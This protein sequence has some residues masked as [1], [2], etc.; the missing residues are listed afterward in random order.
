[1][2]RRRRFAL[3]LAAAA[4]VAVV[5]V[6]TAAALRFTDDSFSPP[7]G[8][9]GSSYSHKLNGDG[10]C[11]PALPYQFRVLNGAL[12]PGLSLAS[13]GQISGTP[14]QSGTYTFW[15]ELSDENPPSAAWCVPKT[16]EREFTIN[17]DPGLRILT[18]SLPQGASVGAPYSV[19]LQ[20]MLVT[21]LSPL[22]GSQPEGLTWSIVPGSG[23]L[24][25]GLTLANGV[26]SGTPTA[27]GTY[28]FQVQAALDATRKHAQTYTLVVRQPVVITP[29]APFNG[30]RA[31]SAAPAEVG[32]SISSTLAV[33]G[34]SGT[35]TWAPTTGALP[36]GVTVSNGSIAGR[37]TTPGVYRFTSTA[38]DS[39]G[40][41][42][43]FP[44]TIAV[45]AKLAISS[46][47]LKP[48]RVG[49]LYRTRLTTTGGVL[50]KLWRITSGPLPHGIHFDRAL[51]VLSGTPTKPGRYRV[52][53]EASDALKVTSTKTFVIVVSA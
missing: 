45:A 16:A 52:T 41:T 19:T 50:P 44:A 39:E 13:N 18:N 43:S 5:F 46:V 15:V 17:I 27:E 31:G 34:G 6:A 14:S 1:M 32:V 21:S 35:Y 4:L 38:T 30:A 47:A 26:I 36:P 33:S 25:P 9:V 22:Q 51:G 20:T 3:L 10:G 49:K 48:A 2:S 40:R 37:P 7:Q 42:A 29:S 12:P 24:P 11:G 8:T 53:F 28:Q 23:S